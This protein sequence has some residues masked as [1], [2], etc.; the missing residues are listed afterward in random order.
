MFS[1]ELVVDVV[2]L[3]ICSS[4]VVDYCIHYVAADSEGDHVDIVSFS[5]ILANDDDIGDMVIIPI[6]VAVDPEARAEDGA[7]RD[8][9]PMDVVHVHH[10]M[11]IGVVEVRGRVDRSVSRRDMTGMT[12]TSIAVTRIVVVWATTWLVGSRATCRGT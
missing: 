1:E 7:R 2:D 3:H 6:G 11:V 8:P 5:Y 9:V 12:G 10:A 4:V